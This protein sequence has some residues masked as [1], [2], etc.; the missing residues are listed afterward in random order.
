MSEPLAVTA[1]NRPGIATMIR[2][3]LPLAL[4]AAAVLAANAHLIYVATKSQPP[5]VA[6]LQQGEGRA[7]QFSAAQSSCSSQSADPR[8][9]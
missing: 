5:C 4:A 6:H 7:G 3:W 9:S 1:K 8:D 2:I